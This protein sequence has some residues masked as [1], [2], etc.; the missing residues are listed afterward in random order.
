VT[1]IERVGQSWRHALRAENKSPQTINGYLLT[2]RI[3]SE[4]LAEQGRPTAA[5]AVTRDDVRGFL[6]DQLDRNKPAT[7]LARYKGLR[8]LFKFAL[9]EGDITATPMTNVQ[10][11]KLVE[12]PPEV[13]SNDQLAALLKVTTGET[14]QERRDHAVI[15]LLVDTGMR[16]GELVGLT[17][18]DVDL[19][20]GVA[21]VLGKGGRHRACPFGAK[22]TRA[23]DRYLRLREQHEYSYADEFFLGS[24]GPLTGN[25]LLQIVRNRGK[26][27]GIEALNPH[28]FRH[29]FAHGW[30]AAGG[31]EGDLMRLTGWRS[32]VMVDRYGASAAAERAR[33]AHRRFSLGDRL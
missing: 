22:T 15:R 21:F 6:A 23:L 5:E 20:E 2:V 31:T 30:L 12:Q 10:P 8:L 19:D 32:R 18:A 17:L 26:S 4:W 3:F 28:R 13:L 33:D 25:G 24:R 1:S 27:V 7:A 16:R 14:F 11:P 29:T 9:A